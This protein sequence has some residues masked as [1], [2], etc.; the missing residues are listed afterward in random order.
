M[1]TNK[2]D[3]EAAM[4]FFEGRPK[5]ACDLTREELVDFVD[6][7]QEWVSGNA[8]GLKWDSERQPGGADTLDLVIQMLSDRGLLVEKEFDGQKIEPWR[9]IE[10]RKKAGEAHPRKE[11]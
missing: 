2:R 9:A 4:R 10:E 6:Q 8:D 3:I 5:R 1:L 7:V 11:D